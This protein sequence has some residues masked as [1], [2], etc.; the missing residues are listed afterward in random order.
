MVLSKIDPVLWVSLDAALINAPTE[1]QEQ[2]SV[3]RSKKMISTDLAK[4]S[5]WKLKGF[6]GIS[7]VMKNMA[8]I[9]EE[10]L[11]YSERS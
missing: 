5:Q 9:G 2:W 1:R 7:E 10:F 6:F 3:S 11:G 4:E 8:L